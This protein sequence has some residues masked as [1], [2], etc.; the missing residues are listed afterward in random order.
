MKSLEI[1]SWK[2]EIKLNIEELEAAENRKSVEGMLE[3]VT[4]DFVFVSHD[5]NVDCVTSSQDKRPNQ[6]RNLRR[7]A[8]C[9]FPT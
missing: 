6:A 2:I 3:L 9:G 5:E 7:G 8:S 1:E 4:D